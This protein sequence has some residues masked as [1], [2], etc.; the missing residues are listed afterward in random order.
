MSIFC[1]FLT[2]DGIAY[3][4]VRRWEGCKKLLKYLR[5]IKRVLYGRVNGLNYSRQTLNI[6][7]GILNIIIFGHLIGYEFVKVLPVNRG[8]VIIILLF[9]YVSHVF[10]VLTRFHAFS[11]HITNINIDNILCLRVSLLK[12]FYVGHRCSDNCCLYS[13]FFKVFF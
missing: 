10:C 13:L 11:V 7:P 4:V 3:N 8:S 9:K 1:F 2:I 12:A 6:D 5:L